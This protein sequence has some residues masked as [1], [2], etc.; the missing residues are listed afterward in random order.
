MLQID[1]FS[2]AAPAPASIGHAAADLAADN[3]G[4]QW[5][6]DATTWLKSFSANIGR[7]FVASEVVSSAIATGLSVHHEQ[8]AWGSIFREAEKAGMIR[9]VGVGRSTNPRHH[10]CFSTLW[11]RA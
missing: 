8:R 10:G 9:A 2:G 7:P 1:L 3:A 6:D 5:R 11:E 4:P